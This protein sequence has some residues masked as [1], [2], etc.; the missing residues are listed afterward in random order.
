MP[1]VAVTGTASFLGGR[2]LRR[3]VDT[4]GADAVLA[5]DIASPPA[6]L[7]GVRHRMVDLTLPGA[8]RRLVDVFDEEEVDTVVHAAFFTDPRRDAAYS[9]EL[10]S[11][12]TLH[13][14]AAAAA[15]GVR[16]LLVRSF[17]AVYGANGRNPNFLT[18]E[19]APARSSRLAWVRDKIEAEDHA[20]SFSER[21]PRLGVSVLRFAALFGAGVHTFYTRIFSKRVVPVLLGYDPLVQLLHPADAL[22]A[23][24]AVL[25]RGPA[26]I[27]NVVPRDTITLLTA[28]HLSDKLTVPVPHLLAYP[29]ADFWWGTGVGE[30]PGGFVDYVRYLFVADG[31]KARRELGFEARHTSRDAL[32]AFL[33]Y[34]Y[35]ST[36]AR[37]REAREAEA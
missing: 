31:E 3:L 12:G 10:E 14:A 5:V 25:A 32:M 27:L 6:A 28:L 23:V 20:L 26:G 22:D 35:P 16:H 1:R 29:G 2:I 19:H 21:Y 4:R 9:H 17:T 37:S 33:E 36:A 34:R 24:E 11:I 30:A 8:D 18:E 13:L 15:G 7:H